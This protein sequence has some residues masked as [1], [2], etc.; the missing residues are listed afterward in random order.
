MRHR[1]AWLALSLFVSWPSAVFAQGSPASS[2]GRAHFENGARAYDIGDY[3][4]A[5]REFRA[6]Y[7][8]SGH[9]DLLYNIYASAERLGA[10][11]EA[12]DALAAFLREAQIEPDR[13]VA[14]EQRLARL[15]ARIDQGETG[16]AAE[17][18]SERE[19][20]P[21]T[22][23]AQPLAPAAAAATTAPSSSARRVSPASIALLSA[24]GAFLVGFGVFAAL[25]N[26]ED[27]RLDDRC[28]T[29]CTNDEVV[30]LRVFNALA[31]VGWIGAA[32]AGAVGLTLLFVQRP[33]RDDAPSEPSVALA[34]LVSPRGAGLALEGRF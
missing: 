25:S 6:A 21:T 16:P 32:A 8:A 23:P 13:R 9:P 2:A 30:R 7:E 29:A 18:E 26:A 12:R 33:D 10:F 14:L 11:V 27:R 24:S 4:L 31:D 28:G 34:P 3:D 17:P 19:P 5:V 15:E 22:Q 1:A 20:G